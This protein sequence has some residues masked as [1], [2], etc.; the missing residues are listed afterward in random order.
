MRKIYN[1]KSRKESERDAV[2]DC[3]S[4]TKYIVDYLFKELQKTDGIIEY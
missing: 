4:K 1:T 2:C 3:V